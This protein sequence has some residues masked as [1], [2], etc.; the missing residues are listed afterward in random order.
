MRER[1]ND[2]CTRPAQIE[3]IIQAGAKRARA[4][5]QPLLEKAR[6]AVGLHAFGSQK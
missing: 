2:L 3:E 1:Y 6:A 5:S 4:I